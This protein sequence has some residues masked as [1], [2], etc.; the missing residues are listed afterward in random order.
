MI[1][2]MDPPADPDREP[3]PERDRADA[4]ARRRAARATSASWAFEVKWDGVRA[5]AYVA[6]RPAAP[7]EPQPRTT[8][9]DALSR[10]RAARPRAGLARGGARRRDR[11]LRRGRAARASSA[12]SG[13]CTST[14]PSAVRRLRQAS[15]PVVY[16]IFDLLWLDGHSL[17]ELPYAERRAAARGARARAAPAWRV[18]AAH[19]RR[20]RARCSRR[21]REQGLEGIVAKRLDSPYEPGRR[22]GAWLKIKNVA[23]PGARDRRLD[24]RRGPARA[25][26]SARCWSATTTDDGALR[27]AGRVGTGFT[28]AELDRAARAARA[29]AA[30]RRRRST[31]RASR[32]ARRVFVRAAS[33]SPRSSSRE[34]TSDGHAARSPPTRACARTRRARGRARATGGG[35]VGRAGAATRHA[36]AETCRA[37]SRRALVDRVAG[38]RQGGRGRGRG[39]RA[40]ALEPRQ[41]AVPAGRLHKG[42]VIDYYARIAPVAAAAPARPAADAQALARTASTGSRSSTRSSARRT[43]PSWVQTV[44]AAAAERKT[45]DYL[46]A[47]DRRRSSGWPTSPT[48]SCTRS[49]SL[50]RRARAPDDDGVRPRP[51]ARRRR[52]SSAAEVGARAAT[53]CSSSSACRAS[54]RPRAPRACRSTCR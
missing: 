15:T 41:G 27:Y 13:A 9:T 36:L 53:A 17:M 20:R 38:A 4:G 8:I 44:D 54:P 46:L 10:A 19:R 24:A 34:W 11:R 2:R 16:V 29:A 12:C 48:S 52:S 39:P 43:G 5:I 50:G 42:D 33:S 21:P 49:L 3:M 1:H 28:E 22:T 23:P 25:S 47:E 32:R 18:P 31:R 26:A 6:A 40:E 14:A 45:I 35:A 30:R 7:G 51:R 37:P